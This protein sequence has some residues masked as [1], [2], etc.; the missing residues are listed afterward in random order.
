M[1]VCVYVYIGG[2]VG[3]DSEGGAQEWSAV[4]TDSCFMH[5]EFV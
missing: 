2:V 5:A 1:F 4:I 3:K